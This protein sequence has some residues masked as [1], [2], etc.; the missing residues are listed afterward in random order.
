MH[1][2]VNIKILIQKVHKMQNK[3]LTSNYL[4]LA[5]KILIVKKHIGNLS[6]QHLHRQQFA[7]DKFQRL[8]HMD[9]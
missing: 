4:T 5:I 8:Y 7:K 9:F 2:K 1:K 6:S 3:N